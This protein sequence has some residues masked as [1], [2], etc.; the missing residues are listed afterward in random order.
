MTDIVKAHCPRC[1]D[2]RR[3]EVHGSL[4]SPW[5]WTDGTH[6]VYGQTDH[7][8]LR[9]CGCE[10]VFYHI[11]SWNSEDWDERF[12]SETGQREIYFPCTIKTYPSSENQSEKPDWIWS[13]NKVDPQLYAILDEMYLAYK[14]DLLILASIGL[15]T[16]LDRSTE[17]LKLD[18]GEF[19]ALRL[20]KL[21]EQGFIGKAEAETLE[22]VTEAGNAAAHRAWAPSRDEFKS[23]LLALEHFIQRNIV[24]EKVALKISMNIPPKPSRSKQPKQINNKG[25]ESE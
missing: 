2:E 23:L 8:L 16:A 22:V 15:R 21:K 13:I 20:R 1:S 17:I 11:E 5:D 25:A 18:P 6:N 7:K 19:L 10:L 9:C 14:M 3:C 12:S 24:S 4:E